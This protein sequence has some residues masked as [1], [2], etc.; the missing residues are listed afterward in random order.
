MI[1]S[2]KKAVLPV[3]II[4]TGLSVL[5]CGCNLSGPAIIYPEEEHGWHVK[6]DNNY[7][8]DEWKEIEKT[9]KDM[10]GFGITLPE[11]FSTLEDAQH[12]VQQRTKLENKN[13]FEGPVTIAMY[14]V[15]DY[16][17]RP[18]SGKQNGL[19]AIINQP[20]QQVIYFQIGNDDEF[21]AAL[22]L[23]Q[24]NLKGVK[25]FV[26]I[27]AGH[28]NAEW[29]DWGY[30]SDP[31]RFDKTDYEDKELCDLL[32]SL[33]IKL[34]IFHS[35]EAG[36]GG[37]LK[38]NQANRLAKHIRMDIGGEVIAP[39]FDVYSI[40]CIFDKD[41]NISD[42]IYRASSSDLLG[43]AGTYRTKGTYKP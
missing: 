17:S 38:E 32:H 40:I 30:G 18:L 7:T 23:L 29:L 25:E 12:I 42:I 1:F 26:L 36:E 34:A 4:I 31:V 21:K 2:I 35:C 19:S 39:L 9:L 43:S 11:R 16:G 10:E 6:A 27:L 14:P 20:D 8:D 22:A 15:F 33:P 5:L 41:N 13:S 24:T 37:T 28:G 3:F